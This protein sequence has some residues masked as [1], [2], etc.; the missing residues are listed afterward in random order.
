MKAALGRVHPPPLMR[1]VHRVSFAQDGPQHTEPTDASKDASFESHHPLPTMRVDPPHAEA[2]DVP[3]DANFELY[4]AAMS[5][6]SR[7]FQPLDEHRPDA[8]SQR[9]INLNNP[10]YY[11]HGL[12]R[13]SSA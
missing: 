3:S 8:F 4:L 5:S 9:V 6:G 12:M 7:P 13:R 10:R 1:R 2:A 11:G